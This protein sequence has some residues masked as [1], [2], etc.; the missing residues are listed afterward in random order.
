VSSPRSTVRWSAYDHEVFGPV[1]PVARFATVDDAVKLASDS[2]YGLSLGILTSDVTRG[3]ALAERI[4]TGIVHI[5]DQ[6]LNDGAHVPFGGVLASG[7]GSRFG[8]A[9]ANIEAF[10]ESRWI[11]ARGGIPRYPF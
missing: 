1:A 4:P 9:T 10:T 2:E 6:T 8:G 3:L 5:N 11:T 7:T